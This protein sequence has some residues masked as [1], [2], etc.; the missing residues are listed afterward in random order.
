MPI[1]NPDV[2]LIC[3]DGKDTEDIMF[4][5][6][7]HSFFLPQKST[8]KKFVRNELDIDDEQLSKFPNNFSVSLTYTRS[9]EIDQKLVQAQAKKAH[10]AI[11]TGIRSLVSKKKFRFQKDGYDLDLT[12]I[13]PTI[14]AMGFPST[15]LEGLYRN[16][17]D[18]VQR[19]FKQYHHDHFKIYN[20]CS[21]R[22]YPMETFQYNCAY[23][24]FHDH[25]PPPFKLIPKFCEDV[26]QYLSLST[27]NTV[28]I[29]CKAG[30]GRTGT[31][32]SVLLVYLRKVKTAA[33][34]LTVFGETRTSNGQGVTIPSQQRYVHYSEL[35]IKKYFWAGQTMAFANQPLKLSNVTLSGPLAKTS[36]PHIDVFQYN[37]LQL[38]KVYSQRSRDKYSKTIKKG[39]RVAINTAVDGDFLVKLYDNGKKLCWFWLHT[40]FL[41]HLHED[42]D[43]FTVR[44]TKRD[45]DNAIK[46]KKHKI[47]PKGWTLT[48]TF[49]KLTAMEKHT[50]Q[51]DK[52][53][54][55]NPQFGRAAASSRT[56]SASVFNKV[57]G[58]VSKKKLR[59][60]QDGFDLDLSYIT[61]KIIAMGYP[62]Q[63]FEGIY[64]NSMPDVQRF[65]DKYHNHHNKIYN[66]CS[67]REYDAKKFELCSHDYR[68]DDHN[69]CPFTMIET[70]CKDVKEYL[71][72]DEENVVAIH[73]KAG[74]GRTGTLI[75]CYLVYA[76]ICETSQMALDMFSLE[77]TANQ[78]GVTIPSQQR[79][80]HYFAK[81]LNGTV[82]VPL[83]LPAPVIVVTGLRLYGPID[84]ESGGTKPYFIVHQKSLD[85]KSK[86]V[87]NW[88]HLYAPG[89][90]CGVWKNTPS[91][92]LPSKIVV[93]NDIKV[94]CY[95]DEED[96]KLCW[97]W[98]NTSFLA[99]AIPEN[100][101]SGKVMLT[102]NLLDG[103]VKD[104]KHR[105]FVQGFS[106]EISFKHF[107]PS[108]DQ[109]PAKDRSTDE[110][111][112]P[113]ASM[114][115]RRMSLN[116]LKD[117][118]NKRS[119]SNAVRQM[120]SKKKRRFQKDS[121]DLDLSYITE[122]IIA[123][124]LPSEKLTGLYRNQMSDVQRF[125]KQ[126]HDQEFKIYNLCSEHDYPA[127]KFGGAAC[128]FPFD[129]HNP[130]NFALIPRICEDI[131]D[132]LLEDD[133][134]VAALHCKA[135]KG[136]TG[137]IIAC[138]LM[139]LR[140]DFCATPE[141]ALQYFARKRT[142]DD[143]G[144]TIPSQQR[145][146]SY[147]Y[148]YLNHFRWVDQ[149]FSFKGP[150]ITL[151][152]FHIN[153]APLAGAAPYFIIKNYD[154]LVYN[155]KKD[156]NAENI[157]NFHTTPT[158]DIHCEVEVQGD[159]KVVFYNKK[160][161]S[162]MWWFWLHTTMLTIK[163]K[164]SVKLFKND[165]DHAIKDKK[166]KLYS[167]ELSVELF[168]DYN[169]QDAK[170]V[171]LKGDSEARSKAQ[172]GGII[173]EL[174]E[175]DEDILS[176]T[177][178]ETEVIAA[179]KARLLEKSVEEQRMRNMLLAHKVVRAGY[180]SKKSGNMMRNW[181]KRY[182][183]LKESSLAYYKTEEDFDLGQVEPLGI[184]PLSLVRN[185][186]QVKQGDKFDISLIA[187]K[188]HKNKE[189]VRLKGKSAD[190]AKGWLDE[191][192]A[193]RNVTQKDME[194]FLRKKSPKGLSGV[195]VWQK[196][197]FVLD[198][199]ERRLMY[200]KN[201]KNEALL[202]SIDMDEVASVG[203]IVSSTAKH[204]EKHR[205]TVHMKSTA[206][207]KAFHLW[208]DSGFLTKS[209]VDAIRQL[210]TTTI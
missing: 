139:F 21:E 52:D 1:I 166:H 147:F 140:L 97:F 56:A 79:Y 48:V 151:K 185:V 64:R 96:E 43:S 24:P 121:F 137:C 208:A 14:V 69:P 70:F 65:F 4:E 105:K 158:L 10:S 66:L 155:Y 202:G 126:Y 36:V 5:L 25:N 84:P 167:P 104:K 169:E 130:P 106:V 20:L 35:W 15:K 2:Y 33:E 103:A 94:L 80:V 18:D 198:R 42:E 133:D 197:Y 17:L 131:E 12:Y 95:D 152:M 23:Y 89:G 128:K 67:E 11:F 3:Y 129:D 170:T 127:A 101:L 146:V 188:D 7:L 115:R 51:T 161:E 183:V 156:K 53:L 99:A 37:G 8:V 54:K 196:R 145:Y 87:F 135:G 200:Y 75:A 57:R 186:E 90:D 176:E 31:L 132:F 174:L 122:N 46:D 207:K 160:D 150:R 153:T 194:G 178:D 164:K 73:C 63:S 74:K 187:S 177:D 100:S 50:F 118:K 191:I 148:E 86:K 30:K 29:H 47:F 83:D 159:F 189:S 173:T 125:F 182:F 45:I 38:S 113:T 16:K 209:W 136:R 27:E 39:L 102:K 210:Y 119:I 13:L 78:K 41:H 172:R 59:F 205:F 93:Q 107:D 85:G 72:G 22:Q 109:L 82:P 71:A 61:K 142:M 143:K 58:L 77:R 117:I 180:L 81:Y 199:K 62:S 49:A 138:L 114:G 44:L 190:H 206:K 108:E 28:S 168:Y 175:D 201:N 34:A 123:M 154:G 112:R 55:E 26:A 144:V 195:A 98:L 111:K 88:K 181:Q 92:H 134:R 116:L 6:H 91:H 19:F 193:R 203:A 162:K 110:V 141:E 165:L 76:G 157:R 149:P 204:R 124:G 60:K 40:S 192:M 171:L 9:Q 68:F 179:E 120:V 184:I 163:G 32:I